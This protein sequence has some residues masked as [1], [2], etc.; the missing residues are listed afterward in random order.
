MLRTVATR[1]FLHPAPIIEYLCLSLCPAKGMQWWTPQHSPC[2]KGLAVY[3]LTRCF[4]V[5][6][7]STVFR[8]AHV[9]F[10]YCHNDV[11][12]KPSPGS[13]IENLWLFIKPVSLQDG[14]LG[15]AHLGSVSGLVC[16]LLW[17]SQGAT[18]L[19]W[20]RL[21]GSSGRSWVHS[22]TSG[23]A[24]WLLTGAVGRRGPLGQMF[25]ILQQA[26]PGMF[27]R[28]S[29]M[30][31]SKNTWVLLLTSWLVSGLPNVQSQSQT[32]NEGVGKYMPLLVSRTA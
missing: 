10:I 32:E 21:G 20:T 18:D 6:Y 4:H 16:L 8:I 30:S 13:G 9:S 22:P 19:G 11:C 31:S 27:S 24:D 17:W 25:L 12:N 28:P 26:S 23:A 1:G 2:P 3:S 15:W 5:K 7:C 29:Q 14:T